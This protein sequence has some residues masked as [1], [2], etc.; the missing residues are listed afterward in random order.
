MTDIAIDC[1]FVEDGK[2]IKLLSIGLVAA[3]GAEL[4]RVCAD[5]YAMEAAMLHPWVRQ[6]V[7]PSLPVTIRP[8]IMLGGKARGWY[9]WDKGHPD[10]GCVF[11]RSQVAEDV[12]N[13]IL[14]TE[15]PVLWADY[16]AYDH[17]ALAQLF[18]PMI[19]LPDGIPMWTADLQQEWARLGRPELPS[20]PGVT[21][22]N[23]L[24]DAREV[25]FRLQWLHELTEIMDGKK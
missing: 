3:D 18:G 22:H 25:M 23:A 6:N 17:V 11:L 10:A 24:S 21:E 20:L 7:V 9:E 8:N 5:P 13:F 12:R 15:D 4:Y 1:E 16:G 19:N 14:T 2:T